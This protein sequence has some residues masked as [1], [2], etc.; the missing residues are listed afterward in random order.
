MSIRGP[1]MRRQV[2]H[3]CRVLTPAHRR[4]GGDLARRLSYATQK[5][6]GLC[7]KLRAAKPPIETAA[8][9]EGFPR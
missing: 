6:E 3:V 9:R 1:H 8:P 7:E 2:A 5:I 4:E